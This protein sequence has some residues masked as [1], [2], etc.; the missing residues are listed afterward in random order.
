MGWFKRLRY[1]PELRA[2]GLKAFKLEPQLGN[3]KRKFA[4]IV[5]STV[6]NFDIKRTSCHGSCDSIS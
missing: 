1:L 6:S 2:L 4:S 3:S 5:C